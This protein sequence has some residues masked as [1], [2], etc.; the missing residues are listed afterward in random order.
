MIQTARREEFEELSDQLD[1]IVNRLW[2]RHFQDFCPSDAWAPPI[3]LYRF[4]RR[5]EVCAD[6]AGVDG[7]SI[8]VRVEPGRLVIR[9]FR[10]APEPTGQGKANMQIIAMEINHGPFCRTVNLPDNIDLARVKTQYRNGLLWIH[11]PLRDQG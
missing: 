2:Q 4:E 6:L 5:L 9:G 8:D 3:N 7:R 11:L 1:S 10:A